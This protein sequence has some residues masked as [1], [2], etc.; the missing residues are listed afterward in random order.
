MLLP[1]NEKCTYCQKPI[2]PGDYVKSGSNYF[3][4]INH[5]IRWNEDRKEEKKDKKS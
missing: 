2:D 5:F 4:S 3:C 1:D